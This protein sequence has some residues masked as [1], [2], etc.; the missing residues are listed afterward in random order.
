MFAAVALLSLNKYVCDA[1]N[2]RFIYFKLIFTAEYIKMPF[3]D[4]GENDLH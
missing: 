3:R 1:T 2:K 4:H